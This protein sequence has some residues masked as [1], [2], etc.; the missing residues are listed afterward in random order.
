M[1][2]GAALAMG[3]VLALGGTGAGGTFGGMTT[4]EGGRYVAATD[5]GVTILGAGAGAS[6]GGLGGI[7]LGADGAT[8]MVSTAGGGT[9]GLA[10]GRAAGGSTT[11]FCWV[12]ARSTSPGREI[13]DKSIL[14]LIPSSLGAERAVFG[15]LGAASERPLRR[16]LR[17][18]SAS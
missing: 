3:A 17:T 11:A 12:I 15:E 6:A 16:C 1:A 2:G 13:F 7:A 4:T 5:A 18:K 14:V 8:A 10:T 9:G